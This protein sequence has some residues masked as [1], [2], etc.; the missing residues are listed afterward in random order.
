MAREMK[1]KMNG[2]APVAL[3]DALEGARRATGDASSSAAPNPEVAAM[4]RRRQFSSAEKRRILVAADACTGTGEI[5]A[6]LRREG[7]YSSHLANWRKLRAAAERTSLEPQQRGRKA[8]PGLSEARHMDQLTQENDRLRRQ[9]AQAH[10]I[11][12]VQKKVC[13]LLGQL[14]D[15]A[16]HEIS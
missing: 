8:D 3:D 6:L 2:P 10:T 11:I 7:I 5:G 14:T 4:A 1:E 12:A 13:T 16:P 15:P 9:L